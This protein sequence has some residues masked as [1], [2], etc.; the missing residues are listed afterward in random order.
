MGGSEFLAFQVARSGKE[1]YRCCRNSKGLLVREAR[2][3]ELYVL[4]GAQ[5]KNNGFGM[6]CPTRS[7][8]SSRDQTGPRGRCLRR[9]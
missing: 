3:E 4:K 9:W 5:Q 2:G 7:L 8:K 6:R 1:K